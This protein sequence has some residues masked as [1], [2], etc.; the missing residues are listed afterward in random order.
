M[1]KRSALRA[2]LVIL[3]L[4]VLA[5]AGFGFS[6]PTQPSQYRPAAKRVSLKLESVLV[7]DARKVAVINGQVVAEGEMIGGAKV[8]SIGKDNVRLRKSGKTISLTL[9]HAQIRR[10][11]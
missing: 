3:S 1:Y 7:S 2:L 9:E 5:S 11:H 6:D 4:S 8:I 10:E